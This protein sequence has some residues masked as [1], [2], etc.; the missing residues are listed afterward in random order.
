MA[1]GSERRATPA[2]C[3]ERTL[4]GT[5]VSATGAVLPDARIY[6]EGRP[7]VL[8]ARSDADGRFTAAGLCEGTAANISAHREGFAPGLAPIVS[9]G[10]G[11]AVANV[12]LQRLGEYRGAGHGAEPCNPRGISPKDA[13]WGGSDAGGGRPR[14]VAPSAAFLPC[15]ETLHGAAPEGEGAGGRAG[16]DLLLQSLGH[17]R[18]QEILLV[19]RVRAAESHGWGKAVPATS[20]LSSS[21]CPHRYHNGTLLERKVYRYGS[22]LVLRGLAPEQA[23]TYHCKASTEAGAIKSAPAQLT[24][25]GEN[26]TGFVSGSIVPGWGVRSGGSP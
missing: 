19:S 20:P 4:Q 26:G 8:L 24:V 17:P 5:V 6:L 18:A 23:G 3:P 12:T 13:W 1:M 22:H 16:G 14:L 2:A 15:R 9:N 25:L 11:L 10:S 21:R 7:P